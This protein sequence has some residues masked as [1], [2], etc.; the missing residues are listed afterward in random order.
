MKKLGR[1]RIRVVDEAGKPIPRLTV[2]TLVGEGNRRGDSVDLEQGANGVEFWLPLGDVDVEVLAEGRA[3]TKAG[4]YDVEA[5]ESID[6]GTVT[7]PI[8]DQN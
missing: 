2:R 3:P 1:L 6:G 7:V 5:G 8:Q 4:S